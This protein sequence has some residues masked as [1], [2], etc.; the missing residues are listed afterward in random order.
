MLKTMSKIQ[1]ALRDGSQT[2]LTLSQD[3]A[4]KVKRHPQYN[5]LVMLKYDQLLT[6]MEN[7]LAQEARG[8]I[9]DEANNWEVVARPFDKFFN[10]G[11]SLAAR[12]DWDTARVQEKLDG[13]LMIVYWYDGQWHV[14][15]S[16]TPDAGG[17]VGSPGR[18]SIQQTF[19]DL[20]WQ[21]W[22]EKGYKLSDLRPNLTFMFELCTKLNRIVVPHEENRLVLLGCRSTTAGT[23][24]N[25][26]D[27]LWAELFAPFE[28]VKTFKLRYL[29]E[30]V[31][32]FD[33]QDGLHQ[34]GYV[35]VDANYNRVKVKHPRYVLFHQ[36]L[37]SLTRKKLLDVVRTGEVSELLAYFP[38][39]HK[40]AQDLDATYTAFVEDAIRTYEEIRH[41]PVQKDFA[42]AAVLSRHKSALFAVR[43][44]K[45][46]SFWS[47]YRTCRL[48][49]IADLLNIR[50]EVD[51]VE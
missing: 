43:A 4:L 50:A 29:D 39:W 24:L 33:D 7:P 13:S 1:A 25:I 47:F 18:D 44:G 30:L 22:T 49:A 31:L 27:P 17:Q 26:H 48:E 15:S 42:A 2:L 35:V 10:S 34:E 11:E 3:L 21:V 5:N 14:A 45:A 19:R 12:I 51:R 28:L 46:P 37:G 32:S 8:I 23:E 9:L 38:E 36:M 41:I 16:G 40:E 20:F 6:P